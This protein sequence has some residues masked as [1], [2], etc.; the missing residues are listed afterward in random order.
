MKLKAIFRSEAGYRAGWRFL[1][2]SIVFFII[3][4][5]FSEIVDLVVNHFRFTIPA[6][7]NAKVLLVQDVI[8][9]MAVVAATLIMARLERRRLCDYGIPGRNSFSRLF[10]SGAIFGFAAVSLLIALIGLAGGY[11]PG[12]LN[13]QGS[14]L[15]IAASWWVLAS[16]A[17][18]FTEEIVFRAYPQFT[19]ASGM[20]FWPAA[21]LISVAF[22]ALHYFTKSDERW[23]DWASVS[24]IAMF[25][26]LTLRRTGDLRFAIGFHAAFDWAAI[27]FYSGPN[28]GNVAADRLLTASF[29]G[30]NSITGGPLGPEASLL[31]FPV[32]AL[33]FFSFH[34]VYRRAVSGWVG[35]AER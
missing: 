25:A 5:V 28:G 6:W 19:L 2:F 15:L 23:T 9:L 12:H 13:L 17:I 27:Y 21:A 34:L 22:G 33:L 8:T 35:S 10:W 24:L 4:S 20:G 26:C 30:S 16:L 3:Q 18:G 32:I 14:A 31:V 7:P 1:L 29:H 11:S